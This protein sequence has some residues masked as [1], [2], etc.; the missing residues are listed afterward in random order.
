MRE[1]TVYTRPQRAGVPGRFD[2]GGCDCV[3]GSAGGRRVAPTF[4][5]RRRV[6]L[7]PNT[8]GKCLRGVITA[9]VV[10][11]PQFIATRRPSCL[12][13]NRLTAAAVI[14]LVGSDLIVVVVVC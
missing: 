4:L 1:S 8:V 6:K 3:I 7:S 9:A 11:S 10:C 12:H 14:E 5:P 2:R 13:S